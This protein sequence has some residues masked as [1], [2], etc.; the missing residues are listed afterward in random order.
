MVVRLECNRPAIG[1]IVD[2]TQCLN[3]TPQG[4][5]DPQV[6]SARESRKKDGWPSS[7]DRERF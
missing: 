4:I 2:N 1:V 5:A 7:A 6:G 3:L